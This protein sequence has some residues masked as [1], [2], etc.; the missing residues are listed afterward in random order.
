MVRIVYFYSFIFFCDFFLA[1][2]KSEVPVRYHGDVWNISACEFCLC[3]NG[4]VQCHK[5]MCE[6]LICEL[7]RIC[8]IILRNRNSLWITSK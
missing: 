6:P 2:C 8:L 5:A 3:E 7:V 4:Q 1:S